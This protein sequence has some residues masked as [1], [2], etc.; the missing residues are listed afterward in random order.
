M[1]LKN[2]ARRPAHAACVLAFSTP[3]PQEGVRPVLSCRNDMTQNGRT[4][5]AKKG[6]YSARRYK[7]DWGILY[8]SRRSA[9]GPKIPP[10]RLLTNF[11]A[12]TK[13]GEFEA[14]NKK[15]GVC[16]SSCDRHH[17]A[18]EM[19]GWDRKQCT[20][21]DSYL[22]DKSLADG[23]GKGTVLHVQQLLQVGLR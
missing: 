22:L 16:H 7:S 11:T 23:Q 19:A 18:A 6:A 14:I 17:R 9:E 8:L 12:A 21:L 4:K 10:E 1:G 2:T 13:T 20:T 15:T 5:E 3:S